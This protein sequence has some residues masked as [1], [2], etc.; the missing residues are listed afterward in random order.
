MIVGRDPESLDE[1]GVARGEPHQPADDRCAF[2]GNG[3]EPPLSIGRERLGADQIE[4][5]A[6]VELAKLEQLDKRTA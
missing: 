5:R 1:A 3:V 4:L 2:G 6:H